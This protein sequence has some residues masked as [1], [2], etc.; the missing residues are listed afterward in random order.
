M[1]F[2]LY[3]GSARQLPTIHD[4]MQYPALSV[5]PVEDPEPLDEAK[6]RGMRRIVHV[7]PELDRT[8]QLLSDAL[9]VYLVA[10][11][12]LCGCYF[13][14]P[15]RATLEEDLQEATDEDLRSW[16]STATYP[17]LEPRVAA[18]RWW[19]RKHA[20]VTSLGRYL[21]NH[22]QD[23]ALLLYVVWDAGDDIAAL[24]QQTITPAFF[25]QAQ[26][27][28]LPARMLFTIVPEVGVATGN[29]QR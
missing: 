29:G 15:D 7:S 14:H 11:E 17:E 28:V 5:E 9:F 23:G 10:P 3:L 16:V 12:G 19:E 1:C 24:E 20:A 27:L 4:D 21:S 18:R 2:M 25:T 26:R 22:V 8:H 6:V 13:E